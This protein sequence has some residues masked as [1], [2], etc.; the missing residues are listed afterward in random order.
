MK[1]IIYILVLATLSCPVFAA[2][3]GTVTGKIKQIDV[4]ALNGNNAGFRVALEGKPSLC[5]NQHTWAY[6]N[7]SDDNYQTAVSV[8]LAAKM[9]GTPVTLYT[10][11]NAG[12]SDYCHIGY[13]VLR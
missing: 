7:R 4:E 10:N 9:A 11:K 5:G 13:I 3:D 8:I 1:K 6:V 12:W 2:W